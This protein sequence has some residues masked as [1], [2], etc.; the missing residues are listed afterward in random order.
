MTVTGE[1]DDDEHSVLRARLSGAPAHGGCPER[2][3]WLRSTWRSARPRRSARRSSAH[4]ASECDAIRLGMSR[5]QAH[6]PRVR[7]QTIIWL[8]ESSTCTATQPAMRLSRNST[9]VFVSPRPRTTSGSTVWKVLPYPWLS[10]ET[11]M[12][13]GGMP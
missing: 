8:L 12:A 6:G 10:T 4:V 2:E 9:E 1:A 7:G 3:P 13:F 5:A 11:A